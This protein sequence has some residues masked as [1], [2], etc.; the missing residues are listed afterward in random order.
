MLTY[1]HSLTGGFVYEDARADAAPLVLTAPTWNIAPRW[2]TGQTYAWTTTLW[3]ASPMAARVVSLAWHLL[4]GVLLWLVARAVVTDAAA[5]FAAGVF[6]LHP[7]Q[8]E[9]VA[10]IAYRSDLI[11][12]CVLLVALACAMRGWLIPAFVIAMGAVLG[13][14]MG[15]MAVALV[16]VALTV[17]RSPHWTP[18]AR[19]YW[20]AA[21]FSALLLLLDHSRGMFFQRPEDMSL[22][23]ASG[24]ALL[25]RMPVPFGLSIEHDW[26]AFTPMAACA[27]VILAAGVLETAWRW[28]SRVA[29]GLMAWIAVAWLPRVVWQLGEGLHERHLYVPMIA[30]S[31]ALG[32]ALFPK[33]AHA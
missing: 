1:A 17:T 25:A 3:D 4:N 32:A 29:L 13:K 31:V 20:L 2:L 15:V 33:G 21:G 19:A 28:R 7:I 18:T 12:A 14:Q 16:P 9:A 10:S 22:S 26:A 24:V 8:T 30:A 11:A 5:T 23:I 27:V 6:L